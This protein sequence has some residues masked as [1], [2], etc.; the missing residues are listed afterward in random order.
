MVTSKLDREILTILYS[1]Y[2]HPNAITYSIT[3][4][5]PNIDIPIKDLASI[6]YINDF[7]ENVTDYILVNFIVEAGIYIKDILPYSDNLYISISYYWY[8][9]PV[10]TKYKLVIM[11]DQQGVT[12]SIYNSLSRNE[13]NKLPRVSLE[14][15]AVSRLVSKLRNVTV[16]GVYSNV[17]V[18][19]LIRSVILTEISHLEIDNTVPEVNL[20]MVPANNLKEY[21][22]ISIPE[23]V[24]VL[25]LPSY[26]Q[27][28]KCGV[29]NADIGTYIC[30]YRLTKEEDL[31]ETVFI[32][33]LYNDKQYDSPGRK[34]LIVS[35]NDARYDNSEY[36]Y[37]LDGDVVKILGGVDVRS[38]E[39]GDNTA[40]S[41]GSAFII[42]NP[43]DLITGTT[44]VDDDEVSNDSK[45]MM[46]GFSAA[47]KADSNIRANYV[48]MGVNIHRAY[49]DISFRLLSPYQIVWKH[50]DIEL[51]FPG[52]P[53]K[54]M[55]QDSLKGIVSITG[56]LQ[57]YYAKYNNE[58]K[59]ISALLNVM[60]NS[61]L[62]ATKDDVSDFS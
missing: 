62:T 44:L 25:D 30:K 47:D 16:D 38:Y 22:H 43:I 60:L 7:K 1:K 61:P 26:I 6:E 56:V 45:V 2:R 34:L 48:G 3:I 5:T 12:G 42:S 40:N 41:E 23:G 32:Y 58:T 52:M 54:F 55:Y 49:S 37:L 59:T 39:K 33:P 18:S 24:H 19:D 51:L 21:V 28:V 53:V 17:T 20:N 9:K 57:S 14:C 4:H 10:T 13:L 27:N 8:N 15:Q 46:K 31:K 11:G 36:T 50:C 35:S 29:Y